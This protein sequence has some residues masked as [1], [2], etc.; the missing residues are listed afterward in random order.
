MIDPS[1]TSQIWK[2]ERGTQ[3]VDALSGMSAAAGHEQA[4][5]ML[6]LLSETPGDD[7]QASAISP[8]AATTSAARFIGVPPWVGARSPDAS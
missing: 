4:G 3:P 8:P 5:M 7:P 2:M 1:G 6:P